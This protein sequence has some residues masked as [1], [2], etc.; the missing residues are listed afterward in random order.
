M[1]D[2]SFKDSLNPEAKRLHEKATLLASTAV[3]NFTKENSGEA[4]GRFQQFCDQIGLNPIEASGR[5]IANWLVY[6]SK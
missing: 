6:R 1:L 4:W 2:V 3:A 5:D